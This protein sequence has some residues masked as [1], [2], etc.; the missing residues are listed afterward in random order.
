MILQTESEEVVRLFQEHHVCRISSSEK[1]QKN[2]NKNI[3]SDYGSSSL[4]TILLF[5]DIY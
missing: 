1:I 4:Y 3:G 2:Y 5:R